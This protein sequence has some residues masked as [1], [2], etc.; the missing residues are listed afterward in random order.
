MTVSGIS[1]VDANVWLAI[2]VDGHIPS[3]RGLKLAMEMSPDPVSRF[4]FFYRPARHCSSAAG[5]RL[6]YFTALRGSAIQ[7]VTASAQAA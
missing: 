3:R 1:L 5:K 4:R 7:A 2:A 6:R